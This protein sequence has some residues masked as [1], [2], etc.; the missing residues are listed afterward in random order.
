MDE[1]FPS[2]RYRGG[3]YGQAGLINRIIEQHYM[4]VVY[5]TRPRAYHAG[6]YGLNRGNK[7]APQGTLAQKID[8]VGRRLNDHDFLVSHFP[9]CEPCSLEVIPWTKDELACLQ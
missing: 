3:N 8:E 2:S 7:D 9:D 1:R 6:W 5:P 4:D